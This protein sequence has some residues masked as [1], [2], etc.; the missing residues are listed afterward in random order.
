M[1]IIQ[2]Y[3][4][5]PPNVASYHLANISEYKSRQKV[6]KMHLEDNKLIIEMFDGSKLSPSLS[7]IRFNTNKESP[8]ETR[9]QFNY[10]GNYVLYRYTDGEDLK[11]L[12]AKNDESKEILKTLIKSSEAGSILFR[13]NGVELI[14]DILLL[15]NNSGRLLTA[16]DLNDKGIVVDFDFES[17]ENRVIITRYE[18]DYSTWYGRYILLIKESKLNNSV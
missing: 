6:K 1:N 8:Y 12:E 13:D 15:R 5:V 14:G 17:I 9:L 3:H 7:D 10:N 2:W 11:K 16:I 18:L 4:E